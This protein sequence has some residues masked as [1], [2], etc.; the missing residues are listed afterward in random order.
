MSEEDPCRDGATGRPLDGSVDDV[1]L[2][3]AQY[4]RMRDPLGREEL[5]AAYRSLV[6]EAL[7]DLPAHAMGAFERAALERRAVRGLGDAIDRYPDSGDIERFPSYASNRVHAAV[8][9]GLQQLDWL[10]RPILRHEPAPLPS[11][12]RPH[13]FEVSGNE[14]GP[15]AA[16]SVDVTPGRSGRGAHPAGTGRP[17]RQD[18]ER[19]PFRALARLVS[20]YRVDLAMRSEDDAADQVRHAMRRLPEQQRTVLTLQFLAGLSL[21]QVGALLGTSLIGARR[22]VEQALSTLRIAIDEDSGSLAAQAG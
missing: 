14:P 9:E 15:A 3:W 16:W 13:A 7:D 22:T 10:P 2:Y 8:T 1:S 12:G 11:A 17:S 19:A 4:R 20:T 21:E 18:D 5:L 6:D